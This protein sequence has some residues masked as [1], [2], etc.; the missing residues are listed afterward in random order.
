MDKNKLQRFNLLVKLHNGNTIQ[1]NNLNYQT[2]TVELLKMNIAYRYKTPADRFEIY[3]N[4]EILGLDSTLLKD[5]IICGQRLPVNKYNV[6]NVII[7]KLH[8]SI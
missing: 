3:W 4:N 1:I 2:A 7:M 6:N 5:I 8:D